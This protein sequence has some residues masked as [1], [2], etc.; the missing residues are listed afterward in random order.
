MDK[1]EK[2][3]HPSAI[4]HK[5]A[6]LG[7]NVSVGPNSIVGKNVQIGEN[8]IIEDNV[9]LDGNVNIGQDV[10]MHRCVTIGPPQHL[11][12]KDYEHS[13]TIQS[14]TILRE[15]VTIHGSTSETPTKIGENC[16]L[17]A[18]SHVGHDCNLGNNVILTNFVKLGG[19]VTVG[20]KAVIGGGTMVHQRTEIGKRAMVASMIAIRSSVPPY[21]MVAETGKRIKI[22]SINR[23]GMSD[24]LNLRKNA[25][26]AMKLLKIETNKKKLLEELSKLKTNESSSLKN[27]INSN[28]KYYKWD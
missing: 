5:N 17:M 28:T 24:D 12:F 7:N 9:R 19:H 23:R 10:Y 8:T 3:I 13:T 6:I 26:Q 20:K 18:F 4:I 14:K 15:F 2:M 16:Y 21:S 25:V 11:S 1:K 27:F 22:V